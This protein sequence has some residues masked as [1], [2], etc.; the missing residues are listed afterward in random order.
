MSATAVAGFVGLALLK[1][2]LS[3]VG[4]KALQ[5]ALGDPKISDACIWTRQTIEEFKAF[6]SEELRRQ[7][8]EYALD[9]LETD[10]KST[11]DNLHHYARLS[12]GSQAKNRSLIEAVSESTTRLVRRSL[13][14]P[15]AYFVTTAAI[16]CRF[17]ALYSLYKLD[18]DPNHIR[19]SK[20]MVDDVVTGLLLS[21]K[22]LSDEMSPEAHFDIVC[23]TKVY[24]EYVDELRPSYKH[25]AFC[26]GT[27]DGHRVTDRYSRE[28]YISQED[29]WPSLRQQVEI[30]LEPLTTPMRQEAQ[31]FMKT[32]NT[33]LCEV[34]RCYDDLCKQIDESYKPP[35]DAEC[36]L[37]IE[38]VDIPDLVKMPGATVKKAME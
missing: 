38:T 23:E 9:E 31:E 25:F 22:S 4:G 27:R 1:G 18:D 26:F 17:F 14:F 28:L 30:A 2:V 24:T 7:L 8:D 37:G 20:G 19:G 21:R 34:I 29:V 10:L 12:L 13:E 35:E 32:A 36:L 6:I 11:L 33:S 3:F 5:S 15:A 16:A